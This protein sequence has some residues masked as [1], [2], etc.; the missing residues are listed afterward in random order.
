MT[1]PI[2]S[3]SAP[4]QIGRLYQ[5][6]GGKY[7]KTINTNTAY[8]GIQAGELFPSITNC[9]SVLNQNL[10]GY[11]TFMYGKSLQAG[12]DQ[13]QA[14]KAYIKYRDVASERGTRI[15]LAIEDFINAGFANPDK[16]EAIY[17]S[18]FWTM[19]ESYK[20]LQRYTKQRN[21]LNVSNDVIYFNAFIEF[22]RKYKPLF[23]AQ[24]ATV[25][26]ETPG[27]NAYAGTTD[28]IA[29]IGGRTIIGDWKST[30]KIKQHVAL[31]LSAVQNATEMTTNMTTL[32]PM[33][34]SDATWAVQL[35]KDGTFSVYEGENNSHAWRDF[36]AV[37][38][39]WQTYAFDG[40]TL[41]GETL[42]KEI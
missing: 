20:E 35:K 1:D 30:S 33:V 10:E 36:S 8:N 32:K 5:R 38:W 6:P 22:C 41:T 39:L 29:E 40:L 34:S 23:T 11:A 4:N 3:I 14:A 2:L 24:E 25:F 26:G 15:H 19:K 12:E 16:F 18:R 42:L 27:G 21:L 17:E 28:F 37:R 7:N 31:Q 13:K 9:I